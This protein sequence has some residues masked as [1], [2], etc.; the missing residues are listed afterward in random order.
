[1]KVYVQ[2]KDYKKAEQFFVKAAALDPKD[3]AKRTRLSR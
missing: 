1:M 2:L 3:P